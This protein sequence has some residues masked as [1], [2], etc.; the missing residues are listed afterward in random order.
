LVMDRC[1]KI[2]HCRFYGKKEYGLD[3]V[4]LQTGVLTAD[5]FACVFKPEG[6]G[7]LRPKE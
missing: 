6:P 1:V 7:L 3:V 5:R 4:G 2:E